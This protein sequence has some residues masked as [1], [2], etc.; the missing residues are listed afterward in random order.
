[1]STPQEA[2]ERALALSRADDCVVIAE[3]TH[4]ANLRWAGNTLTTNGVTRSRRLTVIALRRAGE[5]MAAGAVSRAGVGTDGIEDVVREAERIAA[6]NEPAEDAAPLLPASGPAGRDWDGPSAETGIGVFSG[7][8]PALGEAFS[9]AGAAGDR[10]YGFAEHVVT[11][12]YLGTS[13]GLRL[14]HDQPTGRVELNAKGAGG[15]AWAGVG[16]RDFSDVDVADLTAGL[17]QRLG[18]GLRRIDLPAGRYETLLP[19]TAVADLMIYLYWAAGARDAHDGRTVFSAPG[20]T[21]IGEKL[22]G[23]PVRLY[24]D[25]AAPG[26][27]CAPFVVAHASGRDSSVFDNGMPLGVTDWIADGT[28][29]ALTQTRHSAALTGLPLTPGVDNL[30][31]SAP[32]EDTDLAEMIARTERGLLLTCLWYIRE[33]DPASLLLTGLTRDGVY[34]VENGEVVGQVNNFRFNESPVDMLSR[35]AE[36]GGTRPTLPREWADYFTRA[37]MPPLRIADFNMSTVSN[38]S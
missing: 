35:L 32:G 16:T 17:Q 5:G 23:L 10:L 7:F 26:L 37:A 11:S 13:S 14:R 24:S 19:P 29:A 4:T 6:G 28:L 8:A 18:W 38:A 9:V 25:P 3:E 34:L 21:R 27:E 36:A 33:V 30:L 12:T 20:G 15:S 1:M 22:A 31:M 2:V